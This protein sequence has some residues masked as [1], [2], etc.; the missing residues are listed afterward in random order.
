MHS[1]NALFN[2][3]V[4]YVYGTGA[5]LDLPAAMRAYQKAA[6]SNADG[7][8]EAIEALQQRAE[9]KALHNDG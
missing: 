6:E 4:M 9:W 3:G 1:P 7:A 5:P 8:F 2:L